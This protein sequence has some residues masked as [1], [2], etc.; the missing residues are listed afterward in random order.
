M[1]TPRAAV[2]IELLGRAVDAIR[3]RTLGRRRI[4]VSHEDGNDVDGSWGTDDAIAFDPFPVLRAIHAHRARVVVM[5]QVA[6]IMHG[7]VELTGDLD[8]LWDGDG[9]QGDALANAFA[10]LS[11]HLTDDEGHPATSDRAAFLLPKVLFRTAT[12]SGDCCT[13]HLPWGD[14]DIGGIIDR[15]DVAVTA[16]LTVAYV[17]LPDLITMRR[18]TRRSKDLRRALELQALRAWEQ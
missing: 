5:G 15:A 2:P 10:S 7:S 4:G 8:L 3:S 13:P 11:A 17:A 14:L 9:S 12:A 1:T 16:N 18:A 6:G